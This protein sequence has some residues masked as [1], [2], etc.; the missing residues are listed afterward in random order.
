MLPTCESTNQKA[1]LHILSVLVPHVYFKMCKIDEKSE[2][3]KKGAHRVK[4]KK[5]IH[6]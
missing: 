3:V 2:K 6:S 1:V 5:G 4:K